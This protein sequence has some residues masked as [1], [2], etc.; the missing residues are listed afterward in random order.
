MDPNNYLILAY[1][2]IAV[3]FLLI[4]GELFCTS[5]TLLVLALTAIAAGIG[6][7]FYYDYNNGSSTG[8]FT[9]LGVLIALPIFGG[10]LLR[11]WPKTRLGKRLF[12]S[13]GDEDATLAAMPVNLELEQLR[14]RIG[15]TLS[16]LRP[17]GVCDFDGQRIDT[18]TEGMMVDAGQWVRCVDVRA[19]KVVVRP[20]DKPDLNDLENVDVN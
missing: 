20:V 5:G 11:Y 2:L 13:A 6:L 15:R 14:G 19:G 3:G 8:L 12:L 16:D 4:V 10:F 18:I 1:I 17:S 7:T 9:L